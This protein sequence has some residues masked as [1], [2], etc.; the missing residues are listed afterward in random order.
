METKQAISVHSSTAIGDLDE[1]IAVIEK[2]SRKAWKYARY[3]M[4]AAGGA[5]LIGAYHA[6]TT[7]EAMPAV[8]ELTLS[9]EVM[10]AIA[11]AAS[12]G[13]NNA[14]FDGVVDTLT[15]ATTTGLK[16]LAIIAFI[17]GL[18]AAIIRQS[19]SSMLVPLIIIGAV[20]TL[21]PMLQ[22]VNGEGGGS[23]KKEITIQ[24]VSERSCF[25]L[26]N[27]AAPIGTPGRHFINAQLY[28]YANKPIFVTKELTALRASDSFTDI[29]KN[30]RET[31]TALAIAAGQALTPDQAA[32]LAAATERHQEKVRV[33]N[34]MVVA[35]AFWGI[36]ALLLAGFSLFLRRRVRMVKE[37]L[38]PATPHQPTTPHESKV[39]H[40]DDDNAIEWEEAPSGF[41]FDLTKDTDAQLNPR[42][43][44]VHLDE[45]LRTQPAPGT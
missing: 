8:S 39:A 42:L 4:L 36:P 6:F 3:T 32:I 2:R 12:Q 5:C 27:T 1:Q 17:V 28:A 45:A 35:A 26:L 9:A 21:P 24:C 18:G 38:K 44:P 22:S 34:G 31:I 15:G 43:E 16:F 20:F 37:M 33:R 40:A 41:T 14:P 19:L 13:M 23:A 10:K 29:E 11:D 30:H 7:P 25:S